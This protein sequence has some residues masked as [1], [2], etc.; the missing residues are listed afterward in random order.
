M[1]SSFVRTAAS[2]RRIA[3][4]NFKAFVE[5]T[6]EI[7]DRSQRYSY[8]DAEGEV[9]Y[10]VTCLWCSISPSGSHIILRFAQRGGVVVVFLLGPSGQEEERRGVFHPRQFC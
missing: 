9:A 5:V 3:L 8:G 2:D 4:A 7:G 1:S 6:E 10:I